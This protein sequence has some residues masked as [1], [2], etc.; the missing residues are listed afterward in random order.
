MK[1]DICGE[2]IEELFLNKIKGTIVKINKNGKNKI[3]HVCSEC[4]K[5][6]KD[7]KEKLDK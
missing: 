6:H 7:L 3:Y 1:C 2:K 4:Q 5:K